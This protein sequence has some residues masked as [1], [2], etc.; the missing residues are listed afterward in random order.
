M[1]IDVVD[2]LFVGVISCLSLAWYMV[3]KTKD[4]LLSGKIKSEVEK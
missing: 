3:I 1:S 2:V 4:D